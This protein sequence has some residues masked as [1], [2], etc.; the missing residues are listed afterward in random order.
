MAAAASL[1]CARGDKRSVRT[2]ALLGQLALEFEILG[3]FDTKP[4]FPPDAQNK[5]SQFRGL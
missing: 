2:P 4:E 1:Q 3:N 5:L